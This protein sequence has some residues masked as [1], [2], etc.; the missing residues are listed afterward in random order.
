MPAPTRLDL[1]ATGRD[2]VLQSAT[3]I[4]P[5]T[6]DVEGSDVNLFVG[7]VSVVAD[8]IG[9]QLLYTESRLFLDGA[10][11]VD[12]DRLAF[13]RYQQTR[14]GASP[15]Q[16]VI[17]VFRASAAAGAGTVPS[18]TKLT[19]LGGIEYVMVTPATFAALGTSATANVRAVQGGKATEVGAN[20]IRRFAQPSLLFDTTLQ[21]TN[22]LPAAGGEDAE[23]DDTFRNRV[24]EFWNTARRGTLAA[25]AFGALTVDGVVSAQ[26]IEA[27]TPT[28]LPARVVY[29]YIADSSG[30]SSV[31]LAQAVQVALLEYRAAGIAV[32]VSSS[33]P[34]I[35]DVELDLQFNA[36]VDT[37]TLANTIRATVV[38][39][40]NSLAVN[41][42]LYVAELYSVLQTF[43]SDG[44]V[45]NQG[46]IASPVGDLIP[47]A[48][49]TI[50][51][52]LAHVTID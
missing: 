33:T 14:K 26:A 19:T 3:K 43:K 31:P 25:I 44:L 39:F 27:L 2:R 16:A 30:L 7:S 4:D 8:Q 23:D 46:T 48:G 51:T 37:V 5:G 1:Y 18:G 47:A 20:N 11:D 42:T 52:D 35:V 24:R 29:L 17:R 10:D 49:Q 41:G 12:L 22:D 38:Q 13:D 15:A 40:V 6:V 45:L 36:G 32:L 9:R 28:G 21:V 34:L 50:R